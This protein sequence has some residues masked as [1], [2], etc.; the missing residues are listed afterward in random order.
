MSIEI[1]KETS[2]SNLLEQASLVL[3][4]SGYKE[5]VVYSQIPLDGSGDLQLTRASNGTRI[6]SAGLVEVTPWNIAEYSEDQTQWTSQNATTVTANSTTAPNGTSTADTVTPTA[7]ND[8]HYRGIGL[9]SQ[10]G[11][12]TAFIY[13]KPNG[14]NFFDWGIYNGSSYL[15]R[16]TFDL[17][18]LTYTFTNAGTATIESVGNGWLKCGIS[19]S[20]ASLSTIDLYYRIRPTGG[21]GGFTGNGTSGAFI[22]GAQLN[23]GSTAKPYFP[24]TDRLNV[25]RLTYQ[26]GGGGCPSL[27]LE[28]QSTN[29]VTYSNDATQQGLNNMSATANT[30]TSPDGTQNADTITPSAGTSDHYLITGGASV[31][32]GVIFTASVFVKKKDS[33]YLYFGTGGAAA[34]GSVAYRFSTNTFFNVGGGVTSYN[35]TDMGNG[36]IRL[37]NTGTTGGTDLRI[38]LT[39]SDSSGAR[40]FNANG[41]DG[42]Y[43]WG[44][45]IEQSS[46]VTSAIETTSASATRV[47]DACF[48]T[49]ISSLIGQSQ[50]TIFI[51]AVM[52]PT[53]GGYDCIMSVNDGTFANSVNVFTNPTQ[54]YYFEIYSGGVVQATGMFGALPA[55]RIKFAVAWNSTNSVFYVNGSLLNTS[56]SITTPSGMGSFNFSGPSNSY[57]MGKK[58][59][60]QFLSFTTRL[61]NAE[62]AS[63]TTL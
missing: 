58:E 34:W 9:S 19:G 63:L 1:S 36:W 61:T 8:D 53:A 22:W 15:V 59:V 60:N 62:L 44:L 54:D 24:T 27:L 35:A 30:A 25:P 3:I 50:G 7:V 55:T 56:S 40:T 46:Y 26:N 49:G 13:V 2:M 47:A 31:S 33:D 32:S 41:T 48:K 18:N 17:V 45:Q 57:T 11:E 5:D 38:L 16:A 43:I 21:A 20:N 39:P 28:K 29:L 51:D 6:N 23:I 52:K 12:L 14:Y 37:T 42:L 4:P 10:V